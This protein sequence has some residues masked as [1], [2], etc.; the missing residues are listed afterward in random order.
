MGIEIARNVHT[1]IELGNFAA[2]RGDKRFSLPFHVIRLDDRTGDSK[3]TVDW[4]DTLDSARES[5]N[6]MVDVDDTDNAR[7]GAE[8]M[9]YRRSCYYIRD[10]RN[11]RIYRR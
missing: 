8:H 11:G 10:I 5:I 2:G 4:A 1:G 6:R 3:T 7:G 9:R